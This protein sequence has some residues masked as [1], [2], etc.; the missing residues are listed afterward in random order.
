MA[1]ITYS[2]AGV[3]FTRMVS[4]ED[5]GQWFAINATYK[6]DPILDSTQQYVDTGGTVAQPL[7]L[8][9]A[10]ATVADRATLLD[11]IGTVGTLSKST[12]ESR[13]CV[14]IQGNPLAPLGGTI[15]IADLTFVPV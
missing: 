14:L 2:F 12:G 1:R 13:S 6:A 9:A 5:F 11:A 4:G 7:T 8:R 3:S 15:I 10:F